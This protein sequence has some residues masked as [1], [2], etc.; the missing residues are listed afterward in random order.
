M[1]RQAQL[2]TSSQKKQNENE[3][4]SLFY[5][6]YI[7]FLI[8]EL[9]RETSIF[10]GKTHKIHKQKKS[11]NFCSLMRSPFTSYVC[12]FRSSDFLIWH[13]IIFSERTETRHWT[14]RE[15]ILL[16]ISIRS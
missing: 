4:T 10:F 7:L 14:V 1:K 2:R 12:F 6:T 15:L 3:K 9:I 16:N 11:D 5:D 8:D 13:G